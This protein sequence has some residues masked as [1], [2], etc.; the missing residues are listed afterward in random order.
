MIRF[1]SIK[2]ENMLIRDNKAPPEKASQHNAHYQLIKNEKNKHKSPEAPT[3]QLK[4]DCL[5]NTSRYRWNTFFS[6]WNEF[7]LDRSRNAKPDLSDA[8]LD[9][10]LLT[11][12]RKD[13]ENRL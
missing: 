11:I 10:G 1:D 4:I 13:Y 6:T 12:F 3:T 2:K 9:F 7:P 5:F 8:F